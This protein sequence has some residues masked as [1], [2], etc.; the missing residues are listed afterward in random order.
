MFSLTRS[1]LLRQLPDLNEIIRRLL[2]IVTVSNSI[3]PEADKSRQW[4][5]PLAV[6]RISRNILLATAIVMTVMA[7]RNIKPQFTMCRVYRT[8]KNQVSVRSDK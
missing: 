7:I 5:M 4:E 6:R 2:E 1:N 3:M 8:A